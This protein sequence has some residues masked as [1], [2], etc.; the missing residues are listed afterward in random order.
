[1]GVAYNQDTAFAKEMAA[2]EAQHSQYG[3]P[4]RPYVYHPYPTMMY[5]AG[6]VND[7]PVGIVDREEAKS[8]VERANLEAR[9][10]VAGGQAEA[11]KAWEAEQQ[12]FALMAANRNAQDRNMSEKARAEAAQYEAGASEHVTEIPT[13]PIKPRK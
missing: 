3:A 12:E 10:F 1:M 11:I 13:T 2:H 8:D 5:K 9:G 4:G 7:G 6:R